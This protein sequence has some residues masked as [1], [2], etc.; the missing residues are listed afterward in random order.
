M[1]HMLLPRFCVCVCSGN[2]VYG[3]VYIVVRVLAYVA[4][5]GEA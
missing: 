2:V 3:E 1:Y 5:F 4:I